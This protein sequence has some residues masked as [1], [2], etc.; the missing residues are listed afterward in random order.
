MKFH[1]DLYL[2]FALDWLLRK[3]FTIFFQCHALAKKFFAEKLQKLQ[4]IVSFPT[5]QDFSFQITFISAVL[6]AISDTTKTG[7]RV[8][9]FSLSAMK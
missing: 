6:Y 7:A 2:L 5:N 8:S 9:T 1:E 3:Y 4:S